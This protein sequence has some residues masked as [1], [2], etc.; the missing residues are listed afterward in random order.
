MAADKQQ[1]GARRAVRLQFILQGHTMDGL[2]L[3]QIAEALQTS[4]ATALRDLQMLADEGI[5]ERIPGRE[6]CWRLTPKLIQL[7]R[8]HD[9]EMQRYRAR[10][11]EIDNRYTRTI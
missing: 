11:E 6:D 9:V 10:L 2:R 3:T 8:A 1:Q 7:S 5:A 4:M